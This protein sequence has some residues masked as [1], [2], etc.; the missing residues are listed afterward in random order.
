MAQQVNLDL[1]LES[2]AESHPFGLLYTNRAKTPQQLSHELDRA[3]AE[4]DEELAYLAPAAGFSTLLRAQL[5]WNRRR[6]YCLYSGQPRFFN[7]HAVLDEI[8]YL[9]GRRRTTSTKP[10]AE[11]SGPLKGFWHKHFFDCQFMPRNFI[12]ELENDGNFGRL[13]H[14]DFVPALEAMTGKPWV[15]TEF[16]DD[17]A[18]LLTHVM[19]IGAYE[20]RAGILKRNT[21]SR[22]TG[23]WIV[24]TYDGSRRVYLTLALHAEPEEARIA[25]LRQTAKEFPFVAER[26]DAGK[27]EIAN[28]PTGSTESE[29]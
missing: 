9:E 22:M 19:T 3:M 21:V 12:D 6:N 13:W 18:K 5:A 10:Q 17:V 20:Q 1:T 14:R 23:E 24:Y 7:V 2:G 26:L 27:A 15:G 25:R 28:K 16:N 29:A 8:S 4:L 11:F